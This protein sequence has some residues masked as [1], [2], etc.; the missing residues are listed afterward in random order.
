MESLISNLPIS[1]KVYLIRSSAGGILVYSIPHDNR[2]VPACFCWTDKDKALLFIEGLPFDVPQSIDGIVAV[3]LEDLIPEVI[4]RVLL[5]TLLICAI[6]GWNLVLDAESF[7]NPADILDIVSI[8][9]NP[10]SF[11]AD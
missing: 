9:D 11:L 3:S 2:F 8:I 5:D 6:Q 7:D 10:Q 4:E 1:S